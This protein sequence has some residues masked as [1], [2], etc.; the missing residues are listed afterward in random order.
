VISNEPHIG[1]TCGHDFLVILDGHDFLAHRR[2]HTERRFAS[3]ARARV[4]GF[5]LH[6]NLS[7]TPY[8]GGDESYFAWKC[9]CHYYAS[10]QRA[11]GIYVSVLSVCPSVCSSVCPSVRNVFSPA[12]TNEPLEGLSWNCGIILSTSKWTAELFFLRL[13]DSR[14]PTDCHIWSKPILGHNSV[15]DW[16]IASK[17]GVWVDFINPHEVFEGFRE[18]HENHEIIGN[19]EIVKFWKMWNFS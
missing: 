16:D 19:R 15:L 2:R 5:S 4:L 6:Y 10:A 11:G 3:N 18:I 7:R 1:N 14:W 8:R 17:F 9:D 13:S 12:I